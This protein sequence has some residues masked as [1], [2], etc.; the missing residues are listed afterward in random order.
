VV[1]AIECVPLFH[2]LHKPWFQ[3]NETCEF[4]GNIRVFLLEGGEEV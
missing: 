3:A 2:V 1:V 4:N